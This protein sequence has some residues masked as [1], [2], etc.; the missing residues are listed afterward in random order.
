M[1]PPG[2]VALG[3]G[4]E[5]AQAR[6]FFGGSDAAR[7]ADVIDRGH[8][9]EEAAGQRDVAG[10]ARALF[11]ERLFC[12]LD[13]DFLARLQ[14]FRNQLRAARLRAVAVGAVA[15]LRTATAL[16]A[17][18]P[19]AVTVASAAASRVLHAGAKI[20]AAHAGLPGLAL[21]RIALSG[22]G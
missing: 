10:D 9:D 7:H 13:D 11:A 5:V 3:F 8:V 17:A 1:K 16:V 12:D 21:R 4:H 19:A 22:C 14:H 20:V 2:E 15:L 6:A 18:P